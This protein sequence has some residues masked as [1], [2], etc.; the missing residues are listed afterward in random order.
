M[1]VCEIYMIKAQNSRKGK[2]IKVCC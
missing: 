2:K 1:T